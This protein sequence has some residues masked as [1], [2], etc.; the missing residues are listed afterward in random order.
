MNFLSRN[1]EGL[2]QPHKLHQ[3]IQQARLYDISMFQETKLQIDSASQIRSKWRSNQV[4]M[5]CTQAPRRGVITLIHPRID[6]THLHEITDPNGQFHILVTRIKEENFLLCNTYSDPDTDLNALVTMTTIS[7]HLDNIKQLFS[8]QHTLMAGDFNFV[9]RSTDTNSTSRKPRA[10]A[11]FRTIVEVHDLYDVAAMQSPTPAHTYFRHRR[12]QT[13]ARYDRFHVSVSLLQTSTFKILQRTGDHA[14]ISLHTLADRTPK[15]WRFCDTMLNNPKYIEGLHNV[16]R[17]TLREY[18]TEPTA[19]LQDLQNNID[20][21]MNSSSEVF[22]KIVRN[23]REHA[24]KETKKEKRKT[25]EKEEILIKNLIEARNAYNSA[26]IPTPHLLN[27]LEVAQQ[28]LLLSQ[29]KRVQAA[30][31]QNFINYAGQG[32]RMSR[33]HFSR[34]GRGKAG[35]EITKLT[36]PGQQGMTV[37]D[38]HQI[39]QFMF[40]KYAEIIKEDPSVGTTSIQEFL[41]EE[42]TSSLRK[43]PAEDFLALNSPVLRAELSNIIAELKPISSPGPTGFSNNLLKQICPLI[44]EVLRD[45]GNKLFFDQQMP[46]IDPFLF[47]RLVIFILKPNKPCTDADS[48]RGLSLLE[49]FF[50]L[51]SKVLANRIQKPLRYIQ[52]Q[53]QF[54]F[55]KRKGCLEASRTVIDVIQYAKRKGLPL[56]VISTDFRKAFDSISLNHIEACLEVYQFPEAFKSAFMR[57]S[58]NGTVA[59]E[60]NSSISQDHDIE[61]GVGQGDPKSSFAFNLAA[62]PLNHFLSESPTVPRFK[63]EE[64]EVDPIFFADDDLMLLEGDKIDLIIQMLTKI[65]QFKQV[66]GLTLNL[67][68]CEIMAVGCQ[69]ED[70]RRLINETGMKRVDTLKHLGLLIDENGLLPHVSNIGP[71]QN[72]MDKIADTLST[73]TST[74]LGR[75]LYAKFLLSSR[76]LHKIQNFNFNH[77]QLKDLRDTVLRLTW[78]RHRIGADSPTVRTH[79]ANDRVAQPLRMGGLSIPDPIIQSQAIK[80][81]WARKL[82][83][84][85]QKLTWV[86]ILEHNL[87]E[88]NRPNISAHFRLGVQEWKI[89]GDKLINI[90]A[91]W[92]DVFKSIADFILLSHKFDRQ[93]QLIPITGYEETDFTVINISS[94][95]YAN[96]PVRQFTAAGLIVIGQLFNQDQHGNTNIRDSKPMQQLEMEFNITIPVTVHNSIIAMRNRV[97]R[98]FQNDDGQPIQEVTTT[99]QSIL[100]AQKSGCQHATRLLLRQQRQHWTWGETPRSYFT[101]QNDGAINI[102]SRQF[103][104]CFARTRRSLLPPSMQWT[105]LQVLLR[106]LWTNYKEARTTRNLMSPNPVSPMCSNCGTTQENTSH[107]LFSCPLATFQWNI[108]QELFNSTCRIQNVNHVNIHINSDNVMFN[109]PPEMDSTLQEDLIDIIMV[110]KHVIYRLKFRENRN[111]FPSPRLVIVI[112]S[113][114][115][116]KIIKLRN[117]MNKEAF[118]LTDFLEKLKERAG[119]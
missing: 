78:T 49:G 70:I 51:Y 19:S 33:Y 66:S 21:T 105:S 97:R 112:C 88:I 101:Y 60:V 72:A 113:L 93:W 106:T 77:Q 48:Y 109:H 3:V 8:I 35:R 12:E 64:E 20:F 98:R 73:S 34:A 85:N 86:K 43:C 47:H 39:P 24:I 75:S 99:I 102:T 111:T 53:H 74:P 67:S 17:N 55:T 68:K 30:S 95:I 108:I 71:I 54:G 31:S 104:N 38:R 110:M 76:Y 1:V 59:F 84:N 94:L 36:T 90:S 52:H 91:F 118:F 114:E 11:A 26:Q 45:L 80:L 81:S 16:I 37:L 32:E 87:C 117:Y 5:A 61:A 119:F 65:S 6:P 56:L 42:L 58:R 14:P 2:N 103:S 96:P 62:A 82:L 115:I 4:F 83:E 41:G 57:L 79:I 13:S 18:S 7:N 22:S 10:E 63:I 69:E 107:L 29:T 89:T 92:A 25:K 116:E 9:M 44:Y 46:Q 40:N 15:T 100:R 23:I 27:N 28:A 50:K